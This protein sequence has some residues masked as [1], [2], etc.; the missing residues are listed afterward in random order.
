M[1]TARTGSKKGA[2]VGAAG[3][4][5]ITALVGGSGSS[6]ATAAVV[7]GVLGGAYGDSKDKEN[8]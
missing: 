4:A 3:A 5:G 2:L 1:W 6:V 7:G 8:Q